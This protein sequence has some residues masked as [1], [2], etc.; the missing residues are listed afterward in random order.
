MKKQFA[1]QVYSKNTDGEYT[2]EFM[3]DTVIAATREE[4]MR[5]YLEQNM[6]AKIF[7][8]RDYV[9]PKQQEILPK[10]PIPADNEMSSLEAPPASRNITSP[11]SIVEFEDNGIKFKI[12][13]GNVSKLDWT[14]LDPDEYKIEDAAG[15]TLSKTDLIVKTKQWVKVK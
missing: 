6:R 10:I 4:A 5:P 3:V 8:E 12:E 14:I 7:K 2:G 9:E 11:T 13:N 1:I 15:G